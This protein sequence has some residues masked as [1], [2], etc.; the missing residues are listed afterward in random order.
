VT[1]IEVIAP[2]LAFAIINAMGAGIEP[3]W[4]TPVMGLVAAFTAFAFLR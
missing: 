2:L 4:V 3:K 1:I